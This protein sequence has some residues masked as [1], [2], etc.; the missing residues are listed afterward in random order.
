MWCEVILR[1][2]ESEPTLRRHEYLVLSVNGDVRGPELRDLLQQLSIP[3][4]RAPYDL[5]E[6]RALASRTS[7]RADARWT[8]ASGGAGV[9]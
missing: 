2:S 6:L 7:A 4:V 8:K 1:A 3:I 9:A 5:D